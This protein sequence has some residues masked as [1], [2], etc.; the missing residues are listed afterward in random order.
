MTRCWSSW[1]NW[2]EKHH[3]KKDFCP[4]ACPEPVPGTAGCGDD[5]IITEDKA[6][7]IALQDAGLK[8]SQVDDV[9]THGGSYEGT[10]CYE[11]HIDDDGK[12]YSYYID[13]VTGEILAKG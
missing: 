11:I 10:P 13:A 8:K 5:G 9:H 7:E 2:K 1:T 3:D 12:E 4:D 6:V